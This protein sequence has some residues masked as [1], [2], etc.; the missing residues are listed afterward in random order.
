MVT[1]RR[2]YIFLVCLVSLQATALSAIVL[3][4][5]LLTA[6]ATTS[7]TELAMEIAVTVI[8]GP[9]FLAHWLWAQR[10]A[11]RDPEERAATLRRFYLYLTLA[12]FL[13][14]TAGTTYELLANLSALVFGVV[15]INFEYSPAGT[16]TT[17]V[18]RNLIGMAGFGLFWF[19]HWRIIRADSVAAP[20]VETSAVV[21]RLYVLGMSAVGVNMTTLGV[22]HVMRWLM[23]Q[24][25]GTA[26]IAGLSRATLGE[27]IAT[28][29]IGAAL[30]FFFWRWAQSLFG[31]ATPAERESALRKFYLYAIVFLAA[32]GAVANATLILAGIFRALLGLEPQG[33]LRDPLP[34]VLGLAALWAYHAYL[35]REDE[36]VVG[37]VSRQAGIRR[38]Y[39]YLVAGIGLAA[40]LVGVGGDLSVLIRLVAATNSFGDA[41]REQLA[42]FTAALAA[43]LPV[44]FLP[45]RR[46]QTLATTAGPGGLDDR[47]SIVRKIYLYLYL[48][49]ATM[50]VL[51]SLVYIVYRVLTLILGEGSS[52]DL[53]SDLGQAIA[54]ALIAVGVWLYHGS[55]VRSDNQLNQREQTQ[56]LTDF[57]L[58]V[59]DT[60]TGAF[61]PALIAALQTEFPTIALQLVNV[62]ATDPLPPVA[63]SQLQLATLIIGQWPLTAPAALT[64]A[65]LA[66]PARKLLIPR[67]AA[68][69][70]WAGV[71][72]WNQDAALRQTLHAIK[73]ITRGEDV[74]LAKPPNI[75][76]IIGGIFIA[77]VL[78]VITMSIVGP[79]IDQLFQ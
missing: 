36:K 68:N 9:V 71:E 40:F 60:E 37:E 2:W 23:F 52:A 31:S 34:L 69:W 59:I 1:V 74:S 48:F 38:I 44:W 73:Q 61:G 24:V 58:A 14:A 30:W 21:R 22:V 39:H 67:R 55:A 64:A 15:R 10:L 65:L 62:S 18:L 7:T 47:R 35:L 76:G 5:N 70:D 66:S 75:G 50:T 45:W 77:L 57:H 26:E 33:D 54:Y 12:I 28:L 49:V 3:L 16:T 42:W 17:E 20:E 56:T 63:L 53:G 32:L 25:G 4:Q 13:G 19:Y 6:R 51:G 41:L 72:N 8:G 11:A 27:D 46:A 43:G 79:M 78:F 29:L